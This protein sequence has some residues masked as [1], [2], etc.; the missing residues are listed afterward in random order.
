MCRDDLDY[1]T[2]CFITQ[3]LSVPDCLL[4]LLTAGTSV[5]CQNMLGC[6]LH[7]HVKITFYL[8]FYFCYSSLQGPDT[9]LKCVTRVGLML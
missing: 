6:S 8:L 4:E 5:Y 7:L 1:C 9:E 2:G 3:G